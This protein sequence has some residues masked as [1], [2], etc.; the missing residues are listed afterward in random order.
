MTPN[1]LTQV[2]DHLR[3]SG[4]HLLDLTSSNPTRCGFV[5]DQAAI[6]KAFQSPQ[7]LDY[8]PQAKGLLSARQA[9]AQYYAQD[10]DTRV[11]LES[12][13]MTTSTSEGYSFVFRLLC[14]PGD[15]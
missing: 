10:H 1:R 9:V 3:S 13:C 8:D 12:I 14:N 11:D 6:I 5:Y 15:E 2:V 4:T 7:M